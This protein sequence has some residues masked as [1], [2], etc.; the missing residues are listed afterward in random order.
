MAHNTDHWRTVI[1][2]LCTR[3]SDGLR[4]IDSSCSTESLRTTICN[5]NRTEWN[6]VR[7]V[8]IRVMTK[9]DD[10]AMVFITSMI[11]DRFG[12][13]EILLPINHKNY[14]FRGKKNSQDMKERENLHK[15]LTKEAE[16]VE[17]L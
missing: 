3:M 1:D 16:I 11:T 9:S 7:S 5:G 15:K 12:R 14:N 10:P 17:W 13:H 4:W 8:I 6:P 2:G